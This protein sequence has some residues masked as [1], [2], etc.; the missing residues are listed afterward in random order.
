M[1][2]N[3]PGP[4]VIFGFLAFI[5]GGILHILGVMLQIL[6]GILHILGG[7]RHFST[8]CACTSRVVGEK[9]SSVLSQRERKGLTCVLTA[10]FGSSGAK[11]PT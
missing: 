10:A 1:G 11:K 5:L 2:F 4:R 9:R 6:G 3:C 7:I 8:L